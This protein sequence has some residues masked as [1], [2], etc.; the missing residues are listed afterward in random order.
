M[1]D[2][3][4]ELVVNASR[5]RTRAEQLYQRAV[6]VCARAAEIRLESEAR[7]R[8]SV[9]LHAARLESGVA[10]QVPVVDDVCAEPTIE[11]A[12]ERALLLALTAGEIADHLDRSVELV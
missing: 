3:T 1:R 5:A 4:L 7:V 6:C 9:R 2:E 10:P 11:E 8:R 12:A